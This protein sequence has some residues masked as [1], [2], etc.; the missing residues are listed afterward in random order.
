M[1][2]LRKKLYFKTQHFL[3]DHFHKQYADKMWKD[4]KGY[5]ID[6][7]NPRDLNE[8][9]QWLMCKSDTSAW[10]PLSDKL[11]VRDYL[12]AKGYGS[13][14]VPLL[15]TW[16]RSADIPWDS[17]PQKFVLKCNHDNGSTH[18]IEPGSDRE[19]VGKALDKALRRKYGYWSCELHYNGID[20]CIIAEEF[21]ESDDAVPVDYKVWCFGGKPYY[22]LT[23]SKRN[24]VSTKLS[25]FDTDWN[26]RPDATLESPHYPYGGPDIPKPEMLPQMLEAAAALSQGFPQVRTDFYNPGAGRLYFGEMTFSSA[27]GRM[28]YYSDAF[29]KE[30]GNLVELPR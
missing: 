23:C 21:I 27:A 9:I 16:K 24:A 7:D 30:M 22:I 10:T 13:L 3:M 5:K 11:K 20:P 25:L 19:A 14:L 17:L 28:T 12:T 8:K 18:I 29:L 6:W 4:W 2:S 15:G 1:S 26:P